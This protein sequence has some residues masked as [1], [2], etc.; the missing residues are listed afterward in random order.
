MVSQQKH[1]AYLNAVVLGAVFKLLCL[2]GL[3]VDAATLM[4]MNRDFTK[5]LTVP[6]HHPLK[7]MSWPKL[8]VTGHYIAA[9]PR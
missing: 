6:A 7:N 8:T 4:V 9:E 1:T 5:V 3:I 2:V